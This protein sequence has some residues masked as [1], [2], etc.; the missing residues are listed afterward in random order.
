MD[1]LRFST[2]A[3]LFEIRFYTGVPGTFCRF[4][5]IHSLYTKLLG[6]ERCLAMLPLGVGAARPTGIPAGSAA[7]S[8]G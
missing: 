3:L 6:K 7:L 8:V 5:T 1:F 2:R 4:T